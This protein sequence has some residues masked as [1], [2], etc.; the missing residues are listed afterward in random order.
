MPKVTYCGVHASVDLPEFRLVV[1]RGDTVDL[2][3]DVVK[4]LTATGEWQSGK[5][6]NKPAEGE[7]E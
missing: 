3:A 2:P 4:E 1:K 6:K 7:E 5:S